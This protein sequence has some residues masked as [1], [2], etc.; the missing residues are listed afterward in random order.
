[1]TATLTQTRPA[2]VLFTGK[3]HVTSGAHGAAKSSDGYLDIGLGEP[4]PAAEN[5]PHLSLL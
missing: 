4:H 3:T 1:M 2:K 5:L